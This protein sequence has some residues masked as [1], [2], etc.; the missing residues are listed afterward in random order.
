MELVNDR[1]V[2]RGQ[3]Q[4]GLDLG[5]PVDVH[6]RCGCCA[7]PWVFRIEQRRQT[8][9]YRCDECVR[10]QAAGV[11]STVAEDHERIARWHV[12][13]LAKELG[14]AKNTIR[15]TDADVRRKRSAL[16]SYARQLGAV[17]TAPNETDR[18]AAIAGIPDSIRR[19]AERM[20]ESDR[21]DDY[22]QPPWRRR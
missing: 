6:A 14:E 17:V 12:E 5:D 4:Y 16:D 3:S 21:F 15:T 8:K 18:R 10:H 22:S 2:K 13:R 19:H 7:Y 1:T 11:S 9:S 20:L